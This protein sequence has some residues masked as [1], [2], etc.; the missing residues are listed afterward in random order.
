[1]PSLNTQSPNEASHLDELV[2]IHCS[3]GD[4]VHEEE[5]EEEV[6]AVHVCGLYSIHKRLLIDIIY[7][8]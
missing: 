7:R 4:E 2:W 6:T 8:A 5:D 3:V 1:L